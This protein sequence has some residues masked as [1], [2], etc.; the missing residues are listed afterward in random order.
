MAGLTKTV[1]GKRVLPIHF[2]GIHADGKK[3]KY[4]ERE[5]AS[6]RRIPRSTCPLNRQHYEARSSARQLD[7]NNAGAGWHN[8]QE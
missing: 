4:I 7:M 2:I 5:P 6:V 1:P 3:P 8:F